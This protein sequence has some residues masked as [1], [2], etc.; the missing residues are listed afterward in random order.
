[1]RSSISKS[2][3]T[4]VLAVT[5]LAQAASAGS[6]FYLQGVRSRATFGPFAFKAGSSIKIESGV[7]K[8]NIVGDRSFRLISSD[9]GKTYGVYE[10]VPGRMIDVGDVLFKGLDL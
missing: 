3:A 9:T 1:M 2:I 8:L 6:T 10:L 4:L 5:V 7:F